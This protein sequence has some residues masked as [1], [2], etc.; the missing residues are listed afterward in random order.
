MNEVFDRQMEFHG[1]FP[2][3][4]K[5]IERSL[6]KDG[7]WMGDLDK[8]TYHAL[9][10]WNSSK[11]LDFMRN[12]YKIKLLRD[13]PGLA[14]KKKCFDDGTMFHDI[15]LEGA[16]CVSDAEQLP[17]CRTGKN[18]DKIPTN[19][20][21]T[22]DYKK[23][24]EEQE[25]KG[26]YVVTFEQGVAIQEWKKAIHGCELFEIF[27]HKESVVERAF[28]M[29]DERTGLILKC[30]PDIYNE[31][32]GIIGDAKFATTANGNSWD[33][34]ARTLGYNIQSVHYLHI[35]KKVYPKTDWTFAFFEF[36]KEAPFNCGAKAIPPGLM[37]ATEKMFE[38]LLERVA[39]CYRTGEWGNNWSNEVEFC[40]ENQYIVENY[41]KY[42]NENKGDL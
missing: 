36:Q 16:H 38:S 4:C 18:R 32:F 33:K 12:P 42:I 14:P 8:D 22:S 24:V 29:V 5:A 25:E 7:F 10:G 9:P 11:N 3:E 27:N 35:L 21:N 20:R 13:H 1:G 19:P 15:I 30:C 26:A 34:Q 6:E 39:Q 28:F 2:D 31:D 17:K 37:T 23:W 40:E 41:E